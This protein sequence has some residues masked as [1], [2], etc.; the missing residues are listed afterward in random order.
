[1]L[2][3]RLISLIP[4]FL[5]LIVLPGGQF[6][7]HGIAINIPINMNE[8]LTSLHG[9]AMQKGSLLINFERPKGDP[10]TLPVRLS[11]LY[12]AL[13]WLKTN[14]Q[15]YESVDLSGFHSSFPSLTFAGKDSSVVSTDIIE[16]EFG[17]TVRD[18]LVL[19]N[20]QENNQDFFSMANTDQSPVS[21]IPVAT[22]RPVNLKEQPFGEENAFPWLFPYGVNGLGTKSNVP[23]TDLGYFHSRLYHHDPRWRCDIPYVMSSLNVHEWSVLTSLVSTYMRT[24]KPCSSTSQGFAPITA[25]DVNNV[26]NDPVM[27]Q[28]SYMFTKQ[29]SG[30]AAYW[31]SV[32]LQLL[33]MVKTLGPP[34]YFVTLSC[35][36]NW[37]ELQA[38]LNVNKETCQKQY[39]KDDP[40][41]MSLAF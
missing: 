27:M 15:L 4:V 31:K 19:E 21:S 17:L 8:Q 34:A 39:V 24:Q 40:L 38:F 30:T 12:N 1:M 14:N 9:S 3:K 35:N 41:M 37:P 20:Q 10:V 32:L 7:Q 26:R 33:A 6:A 22:Q 16:E 13:V 29:I 18:S 23:I 11:V 25:Q 28:N 2:E 5:T 36:V